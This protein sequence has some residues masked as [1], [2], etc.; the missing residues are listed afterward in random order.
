MECRFPDLNCPFEKIPE[1]RKICAVCATLDDDIAYRDY[2]KEKYSSEEGLLT[3][4]MNNIPDF[5]YFKDKECRYTEVSEAFAEKMRMTR[6]ELI[7]KKVTDIYPG[8]WGEKMH[9]SDLK[10]IQKERKV[11]DKEDKVTL[12][13]GEI[14]WMS[15][16]KVPRY[17]KSGNVIGM[18]GISR[19][20][21]QRKEMERELIGLNQ[22]QN[23]IIENAN[24]IVE[25]HDEL[26]NIMVWN[27]A[28][29]EI[30]GYTKEEV[31]G[32]NKVWDWLYPDEDYRSE[33]ISKAAKIARGEETIEDY[34]FT[35]ECKNGEKKTISWNSRGIRDENDNLIGA[36]SIGI[37]ITIRK[38]AERREKSLNALFRYNIKNRIQVVENYLNLLVGEVVSERGKKNLEE[39]RVIIRDVLDLIEKVRIL[40]EIKQDKPREAYISPVIVSAIENNRYIKNRIQVVENYLN[41]LV[42]EVV[43]ERGKKNLEEV[44]V[45]IRDVLDLIEKVR[46]LREIKQDKP[47]EFE[48]SPL[49]ASA[50]ENLRFY[51]KDRGIEIEGD[52]CE[53]IVLGGLLLEELFSNLIKNTIQHSGGNKLKISHEETV[54]EC[55]IS[56]EDNGDGIPDEDKNSIFDWGFKREKSSGSGLGLTLAKEIAENYGGTLMVNDSDLGGAR[57]DVHLQKA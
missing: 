14:R 34:E 17:D 57:F 37:D 18:L 49:I 42:G 44:R 52:D 55:V 54:D 1:A 27:K 40:R 33:V 56:F 43:S 16:S 12:P 29:E 36:I 32:D 46:I 8:E 25:F 5:V 35:V 3:S 26:G 4:L 20:I 53:S 19:D 9:N 24:V 48:I 31:L 7:G 51:A 11:V 41:L 38:R 6:R 45:I 2:V 23:A 30:T 10:V 22:F 15:T 50:I 21:T 39:V 13:T 28:A 47:R